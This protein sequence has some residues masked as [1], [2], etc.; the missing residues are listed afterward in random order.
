MTF[1]VLKTGT[2]TATF[3]N[4]DASGTSTEH[5]TVT[6]TSA[7]ASSPQ[8]S[9]TVGLPGASGSTG[10]SWQPTYDTSSLNLKSNTVQSGSEIGAPGTQ[11]MTFQVLKTGTSTATFDLTP[12]SGSSTER[13]S[14]SLS[15]G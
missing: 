10:Y 11:V 12:P 14:V 15:V 13:I 3:D 7:Q 9:F 2:S 5:V 1:Q 6:V 4:I 8:V